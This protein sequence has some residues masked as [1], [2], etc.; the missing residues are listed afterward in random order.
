[1]RRHLWTV[2]GASIKLKTDGEHD[3]EIYVSHL[4]LKTY[5]PS[6]EVEEQAAEEVNRQHIAF[7][8]PVNPCP[9]LPDVMT[10][11]GDQVCHKWVG[12]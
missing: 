11:Q 1:M 5:S 10:Y 12:I 8:H 4:F 7:L 6:V 9:P 2:E 3:W